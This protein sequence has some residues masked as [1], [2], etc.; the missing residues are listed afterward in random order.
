[1]ACMHMSGR[2]GG[3]EEEEEEEVLSPCAVLC[4]LTKQQVLAW[5]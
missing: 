5:S 1:M 4:K 2:E 3:H